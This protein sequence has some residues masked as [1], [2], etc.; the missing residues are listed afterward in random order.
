MKHGYFNVR[1]IEKK[2]GRGEERAGGGDGGGRGGDGGG[3]GG[4][5]GGGR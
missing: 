4:G 2:G 5:R 1:S 3:D